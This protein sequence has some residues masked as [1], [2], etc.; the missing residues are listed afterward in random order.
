LFDE[1]ITVPGEL[2]VGMIHPRNVSHIADSK[3][4]VYGQMKL[5]E[6]CVQ[7]PLDPVRILAKI[8]TDRDF[9]LH[10]GTSYS[11]PHLA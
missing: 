3:P 8:F 1:G 11:Q 5:S 10:S 4:T 2:I 6:D 9:T 7:N